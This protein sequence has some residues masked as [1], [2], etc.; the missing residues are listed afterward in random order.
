MNFKNFFQRFKVQKVK[1]SFFYYE[2]GIFI[3]FLVLAFFLREKPLL[4]VE[5]DF[6]NFTSNNF[7]SNFTGNFTEENN[8]LNVKN[9][10]LKLPSYSFLKKRNPFSPEG[11]YI[12]KPIPENPFSLIGI[13]AGSSPSALLKSFT[14]EIIVVKEG[15]KLIDGSRVVKIGENFVII[16]RLGKKRELKLFSVEVEKWKPKKNF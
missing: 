3:L 5:K 7:T 9:A 11:S 2:I 8:T 6:A 14:G 1:A 16:E 15:D 13:R 4:K 10:T 12:G